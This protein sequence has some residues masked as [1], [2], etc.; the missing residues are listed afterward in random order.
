MPRS[1]VTVHGQNGLKTNRCFNL[2]GGVSTFPHSPPTGRSARA[3]VKPIGGG[4][5]LDAD[6]PARPD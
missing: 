6:A 1:S 2:A 3:C 5:S 4:F